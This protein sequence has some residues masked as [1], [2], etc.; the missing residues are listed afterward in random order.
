M[1]LTF[2]LLSA[3]FFQ[4]TI[5]KYDPPQT[6]LKAWRAT[7]E[8]WLVTQQKMTQNSDSDIWSGVFVSKLFCRQQQSYT[9]THTHTAMSLCLLLVVTVS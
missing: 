1:H 4:Q 2:V 7:L 8:T 6:S 5:N 3:L 9:R